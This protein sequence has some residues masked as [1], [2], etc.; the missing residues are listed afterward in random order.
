MTSAAVTITAGSTWSMSARPGTMKRGSRRR[1]NVD[2]L[3]LVMAGIV[4]MVI[5]ALIVTG[6]V[7]GVYALAGLVM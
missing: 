2:I 6:C 4:L 7:V 5:G 1:N 3:K